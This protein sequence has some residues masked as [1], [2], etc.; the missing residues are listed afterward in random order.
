MLKVTMRPDKTAPAAAK[1]PPPGKP[2]PS[3]RVQ[4]ARPEPAREGPLPSPHVHPRHFATHMTGVIVA[5]ALRLGLGLALAV[6]CG[7]LIGGFVSM[8]I[9]ADAI[10][11]QTFIAVGLA[12]EEVDGVRLWL[13][14]GAI[15]GGVGY[16]IRCV[17]R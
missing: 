14:S 1:V 15:S 3:L 6:F 9:I 13:G 2:T 5:S 16:L 11:A 8:T 4:G 7:A 12:V 17:G 10:D